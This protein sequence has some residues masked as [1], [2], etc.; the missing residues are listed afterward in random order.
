MSDLREEKFHLILFLLF[1]SIPICYLI[2]ILYA[3]QSN[4]N[5]NKRVE[6]FFSITLSIRKKTFPLHS[7]AV[8]KQTAAA[9]KKQ[10]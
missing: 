5:I 8:D 3:L 7:R 9:K 4:F 2:F 6:A 10:Q 1:Q